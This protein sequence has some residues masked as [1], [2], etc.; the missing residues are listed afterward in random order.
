M[1]Q[2]IRVSSILKVAFILSCCKEQ[3]EAESGYQDEHEERYHI[4]D[5]FYHYS[6]KHSCTLEQ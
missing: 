4:F 6:Q 3:S 5:Y 2:Q 1:H